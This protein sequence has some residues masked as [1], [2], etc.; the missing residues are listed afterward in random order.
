MK[1]FS[2]VVLLT[3]TLIL[4][5]VPF[6]FAQTDNVIQVVEEK[7]VTLIGEGFDED[8]EELAFLWKQISGPTVTLSDP[9]TERPTFM[10]PSVQSGRTITLVFELTVTDPQGASSKDT[11]TLRVV[12]TN[13]PPTVDAGRDQV[14]YP[15]VSAITFFASANDPDKDELKYSWKQ[16]SGQPVELSSIN[17]KYIIITSDQINF[18][19]IEPLI[20]QV[21]V[22][23]GFGGVASSQVALHPFFSVLQN[24]LITVDAGAPQTV[25]EGQ[26][27]TLNGAGATSNGQPIRFTWAQIIGPYAPLDS[28]VGEQVSFVAPQIGDYPVI[29][30]FQLTGYSKGN[31][32]ASDL[33]MIK[34]L[35]GNSSPEANAGPDKNVR[36]SSFVRLAGQGIDPDGDKLRFE[37]KQTSGLKVVLDRESPTEVSFWSPRISGF[38][39]DLDFEL[40]VTDPQGNSDVDSVRVTVSLGDY[41]PTAYAGEDRTVYGGTKVTIS[42]I[43]WS[44]DGN[45]QVQWAQLSG[46]KVAFTEDY[47]RVEFTAPDVIP[48]E[49]KRLVFQLSVTDSSSR[50]A[51]DTVNVIVVAKNNPPT[52]SVGDDITIDEGTSANIFCKGSDPDSDTLTYSWSSDA[53]Q[54]LTQISPTTVRFDAPNVVK[55]TTVAVTCSV[56]DGSISRSDSMNVNIVNTISMGIVANAGADKIVDEQVKVTLDGAKSY[57]PEG[58]QLSYKWRQTSGDAVTLSSSTAIS[59][60]F[61]SPIVA[62]NQVKVLVFELTVFDANQRSSIDTVTV[63]VDPINAPPSASAG[64]MQ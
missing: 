14:I 20:F 5:V 43:A 24:P 55:M 1:L 32:F 62:N 52:V 16:I 54:Y 30:S 4:G 44:T 57:D 53:G 58:Q 39:E 13:A 23:D 50:R 35:P 28:Y 36:Q 22:D 34:V 27:V 56:S 7:L 38:A 61:T 25:R 11:V 49:I 47:E 17:A 18:D 26:T 21:T 63:T 19:D 33:V 41:L 9:T 6:A 31:G 10:A 59:P 12:S 2:P 64:A 40:K 15:T 3:I 42:G 60:T 46:E 48:G 51:S 29:L 37:W 45:P 8:N